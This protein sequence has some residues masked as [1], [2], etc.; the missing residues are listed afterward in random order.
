MKRILLFLLVAILL[1][2]CG[3]AQQGGAPASDTAA[4]P[5]EAPAEEP[6]GGE[7]AIEAAAAEERAALLEDR[8]DAGNSATGVE[9]EAQAQAQ[10]DRR[11]IYTAS[12]QLRVDDPRAIALSLQALAQR[13]GGYVSGANVFQIDENSSR[14]TV[15]IRVQAEQ[16][17]EA[18][19]EIRSLATEELNATIDSEDVT[20]EYVDLEARIENLERTETELQALLTEAREQGGKTEDILAIYRE[21]TGVRAEIESFQ[22]R[23]NVLRDA[24]QLATINV[25]LVPPETHVELLD[26]RW[27]ALRT[28]R[29]A[30]RTLTEALQALTD[31][32]IY[33]L[34]AVAPILL[35]VALFFYVFYRI[36]LWFRPQ[37]TRPATP[38]E[39]RA[40]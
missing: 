25:E 40:E 38:T 7:E 5:A 30:A 36:A 26:E 8:A 35:L 3:G 28:V 34:I 16:F 1:V 12:L 11:I 20:E 15:Q 23:L 32:S 21:L 24:V 14:A 29:Q 33:F 4:R 9:G 37:P 2:A 19:V 31:L 39:P 6:A 22:G 13:Y 18:L 10:L 27:S 17:D